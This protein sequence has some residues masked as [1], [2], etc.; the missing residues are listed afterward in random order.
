MGWH[1]V[2]EETKGKKIISR[3]VANATKISSGQ[4]ILCVAIA[5]LV[6]YKIYL[7]DVA[8]I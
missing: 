8:F 3:P 2:K 7:Y 1:E 6:T 5:Q 4:S